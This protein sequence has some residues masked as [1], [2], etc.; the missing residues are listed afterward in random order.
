MSYEQLESPEFAEYAFSERSRLSLQSQRHFPH[1]AITE[2]PISTLADLKHCVRGRSA[3]VAK[4]DEW[5]DYAQSEGGGIPVVVSAYG[6]GAA[7]SLRL[8]GRTDA[9]FDPSFK[10]A[11]V[12]VKD[13]EGCSCAEGKCIRAKGTLHANYAVDIKVNLP[14]L[15]D[16]PDLTDK[17]KKRFQ[18]AVTTVLAPHEQKHVAAFRK[19]RGKTSRPFDITVCESEFDSTMQTMFEEEEGPRREAVQ[20]ESDALDPFYFD[21]EL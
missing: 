13:G 1:Q 19:Y 9:S 17:Q 11:G 15:S 14:K 8:E 21:F 10:T 7:G 20:A 16:Y 2:A 6:D 18:K 12:K 4:S 5:K 3:D